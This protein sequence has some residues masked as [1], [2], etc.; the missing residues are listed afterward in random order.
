MTADEVF[1]MDALY[2]TF[3]VGAYLRRN[4]RASAGAGGGSREDSRDGVWRDVG[5]G[6]RAMRI[7]S[8]DG[9]RA[10]MKSGLTLKA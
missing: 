8:C 2:S 9:L 5:A 4:K 3:V 1:D 7:T 10:A 6:K